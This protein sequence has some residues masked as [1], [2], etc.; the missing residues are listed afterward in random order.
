M[1]YAGKLKLIAIVNT[2]GGIVPAVLIT[3]LQPNITWIAF[4]MHLR[5]SLVYS[6]SIGTMAFAVLNPLGPR[7]VQLR[8]PYS[9]LA[10]AAILAM[11]AVAG[12]LVACLFFRAAGWISASEFHGELV[13]GIRIAIAFT[14]L[15]GAGVTLFE[16]LTGRLREARLEVRT[17]QLEEERAHK[18]ATQAR[19]SSLE[20]RIHPH[21]L[22]NTLNSISALVRE[23]PAAAER[24]IERLAALLRY[25]LDVAAR[26]LVALEDELRIVE[27]YLDIEKTRFGDRLRFSIAAPRDLMMLEVP[28]LSIQSL[29][30]N[31]I[32]HAIAESRRGGEIRVTAR[33]QDGS[34]VLEVTD[35]GPGFD[36]RALKPGHGLENLRE[37]LSTLYDGAGRIEIARREE[38]TVVSVAVPCKRVLA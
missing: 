26:P 25:S 19:L 18:L 24:T 5:F 38:R 28:P 31:S 36:W 27:D 22:F 11:L 4:F 3:M 10:L 16:T 12:S 9:L 21:F 32:K 20:S 30:E 7:L 8:R 14:I 17:R 13:G 34:L 2:A 15:I 23:D 37:R 35:D 1:T 33:E 29:V 6:Y